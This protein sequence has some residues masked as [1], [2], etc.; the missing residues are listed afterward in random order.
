MQE[1]DDI[2]P[3]LSNNNPM[4]END[5]PD[6]T[7]I[8]TAEELLRSCETNELTLHIIEGDSSNFINRNT[9]VISTIINE[10]LFLIRRDQYSATKEKISR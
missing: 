8:Q 10:I 6:E 9:S 3:G 1:E 4:P 7:S 5:E 2:E